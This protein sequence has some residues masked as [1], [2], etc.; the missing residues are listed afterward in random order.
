MSR[1]L[2]DSREIFVANGDKFRKIE[3]N[4]RSHT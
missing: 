2:R 4:E 3:A 1:N